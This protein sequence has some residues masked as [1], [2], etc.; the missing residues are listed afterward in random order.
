MQTFQYRGYDIPVD[1]MRLTGGG[2]ETFDAIS[3]WHFGLLKKHIGIAPH[4]NV[5]EIGCGI[6]RDAIPLS[7]YLT[8]GQYIGIDITRRSIEWCN[9]TIAVR[10]PNFK[11]V[12]FDVED[13]LHNSGGLLKIQDTRILLPDASVD[14][15]F[16]F[17]VFTHMFRPGIEHYLQQFRRLIK[18]DGL[19]YATTCIYT[20]EILEAARRTDLTAWKLRF[21][22]EVEPG[23]RI[24]DLRHPLGAVAY[25]REVWDD[26]VANAGFVYARP[27]LNGSWSGFYSHPDEG[28]DVAILKVRP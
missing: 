8:E 2:P 10:H 18:P 1:L 12:H 13:Q 14:R 7:E 9:S 6:G 28:Q 3:Q 4:H 20:D 16:L 17:S 15:I 21:E 27:F 24:N 5:L 22:H 23:C 26:M 11:F 19:I 25:T